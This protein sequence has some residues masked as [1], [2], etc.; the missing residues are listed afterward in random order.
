[1]TSPRGPD[2]AE[3]ENPYQAPRARVGDD[4]E[5]DPAEIA[6]ARVVLEVGQARATFVRICGHFCLL[7]SSG[8][9]I[10]IG[11]IVVGNYLWIWNRPGTGPPSLDRPR[12]VVLALIG[13][14][15]VLLPALGIGLKN[16]R[17]EARWAA[18]LIAFCATI[19]FGAAAVELW[20]RFGS[21]NP[22]L[23]FFFLVALALTGFWKSSRTGAL[24]STE[25]RA[26][27][28]LNQRHRR[29]L[30]QSARAG[31]MF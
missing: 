12:L 27:R 20:F 11:C 24:F 14:F 19:V 26:A 17:P 5:F 22:V 15:V 6:R 31:R 2:V 18:L 29:G 8:I 28:D 9:L 23:L 7:T 30:L 10:A 3:F 13:V 16:H 25:Y 4:P 21:L 1:M